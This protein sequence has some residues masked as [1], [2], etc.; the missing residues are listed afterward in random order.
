MHSNPYIYGVYGQIH[1]KNLNMQNGTLLS[2]LS[3][4]YNQ[5][6]PSKRCSYYSHYIIPVYIRHKTVLPDYCNKKESICT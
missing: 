5:L 3:S 6:A 2:A 4:I 1:L